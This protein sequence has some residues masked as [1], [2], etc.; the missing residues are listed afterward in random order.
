MNTVYVLQLHCQQCGRRDSWETSIPL[1]PGE[2]IAL[3]H[4]CGPTSSGP[5]MVRRRRK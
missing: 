1:Q 2:T 5:W 4:L 3:T